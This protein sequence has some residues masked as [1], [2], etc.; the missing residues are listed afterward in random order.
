MKNLL[1]F[2][3]SFADEI[4]QS[5][6]QAVYNKMP[7][8]AAMMVKRLKLVS[9]HDLLRKST[10]WQTVKSYGIS[11]DD[12]WNQFQL[13]KMH[14]TG[15]QDVVLFE[16]AAGRL[17]TDK[18]IPCPNLDTALNGLNFIK[19][20]RHLVDAD[21]ETKALLAEYDQ[22]MAAAVQYFINLQR[23]SFDAFV[24]KAIIREIKRACPHI[25][26]IPCF[27]S[28]VSYNDACLSDVSNAEFSHLQT[29]QYEIR[30][31][32]LTEKN[33]YILAEQILQC[34]TKQAA[35]DWHLFDFNPCLEQDKYFAT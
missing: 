34:F 35:W 32:H 1:I 16:T 7:V 14:Y 24:S 12:L 10:H 8:V 29:D 26:I 6:F 25:L 2:G 13:F 23:P 20:H 18:Q 30:R 3:D 4:P 31:N 22:T 5:R 17:T 19:K 11:G 27:N 28:C 21:R 33:T 15:E 9:Y